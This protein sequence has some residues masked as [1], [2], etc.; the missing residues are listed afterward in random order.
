MHAELA[1]LGGTQAAGLEQTAASMDELTSTVRANAHNAHR[2]SAMTCIANERACAG[3]KVVDQAVAAMDDIEHASTK[4]SDI[5]SVIDAIAFQTNLLAL[6]AA[7]E[8]AR[9]GEQGRGFAVVATEVRNLASRSATVAKETKS[10]INDSATQVQHGTKLVNESGEIL[11]EIVVAVREVIK[12]VDEIAGASAEQAASIEQMGDAVRATDTR[13]HYHSELRT[14]ALAL[15][16]ENTHALDALNTILSGFETTPIAPPAANVVTTAYEYDRAERA[17]PRCTAR[18]RALGAIRLM[19][20]VL[21]RRR[22][23][24]PPPV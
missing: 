3:G 14:T 7:V 8:A 24:K 16:D 13:T 9:E 17:A 19:L 1:N 6:N 11:H 4:I 22:R 2:S 21:R 23:H 20:K 15:S 5:I 18:P 12:L 10:L